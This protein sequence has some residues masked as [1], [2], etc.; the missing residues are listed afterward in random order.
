LWFKWIN[1]NLCF[2]LICVQILRIFE[3]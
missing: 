2:I 3:Q 1:N